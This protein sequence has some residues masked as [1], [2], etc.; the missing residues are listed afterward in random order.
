MRIF[1]EKP[2]CIIDNQIISILKK[3]GTLWK[4]VAT[5]R[6]L[7]GLKCDID[8]DSIYNNCIKKSKPISKINLINDI[9]KINISNKKYNDLLN[10]IIFKNKANYKISVTPPLLKYKHPVSIILN[11]NSF[12]NSLDFTP[13]N[14]KSNIDFNVIL[15]NYFKNELSCNADINGLKQLCLRGKFKNSVIEKTT[16]KFINK[17]LKC[18]S[19]KSPKSYILKNNK[20]LHRTCLVCNSVSCI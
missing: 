8:N 19:C 18:I 12:K 11:Y 6:F 16:I 4:L 2:L 17:Y 9:P 14:V 5:S 20:K 3:V 13:N 10:N 7:V 15:I 1:L